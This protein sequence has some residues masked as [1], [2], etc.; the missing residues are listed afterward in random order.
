M[1]DLN[2]T[3][4]HKSS[5]YGHLEVTRLLLD[6]GGD[7]KAKDDV[8]STPLHYSSGFGHLEV[9]RLLLDRGGDPKAKNNNGA[10]RSNEIERDR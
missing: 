6:R 4:L 2:R 5:L 1:Q 10:T 3:P 9:T 7:P 8:G